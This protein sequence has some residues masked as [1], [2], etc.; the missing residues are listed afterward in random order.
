MKFTGT[1][2]VSA[3]LLAIVNAQK[4]SIIAITSPLTGT[5]Y[6]AGT[7]AIISW[8]N[9]TVDTITQILLA[10]GPS[11][12]L[13]PLMTV[14]QNVKA[15]DG[16]YVWKIPAELADGDD[17]AF[18]FGT[19]PDMAFT[20]QFSIHGGTGTSVPVSSPATPAAANPPSIGANS[21]P[22]N[23]N[24]AAVPASASGATAGNSTA[25]TTHSGATSS[26]HTVSGSVVA[27]IGVSAF[28]V[29]QL[30]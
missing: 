6:K 29:S 9:P 26:F 11:T 10:K 8:V 20:G 25:Q 3:T 30:L 17:Y 2:F 12:A 7:E 4:A 18:E 15:S 19:S 1:L 24:S 23:A 14:A 16:K 21:V 28:M 5:Q 22:A 13:Q 27:A